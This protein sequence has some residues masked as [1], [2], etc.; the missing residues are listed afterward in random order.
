[1]NYKD[2]GNENFLMVYQMELQKAMSLVQE[3]RLELRDMAVFMGLMS[4]MNWRSGKVRIT[5]KALSK[6]LGI[7]FPVCV[8]SITRLRKELL[9]V[10]VKEERSGEL[11]FLLNPYV[12]SVG[13]AQRKGYLWKQFIDVV[14]PDR[15][16]G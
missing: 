15:D 7:S 10:R 12:A 14:D 5:A 3:R 6:K 16:D 13:G 8:S 11:Y 2:N 4:E 9:V 1:M